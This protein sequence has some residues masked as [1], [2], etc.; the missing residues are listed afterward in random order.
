MKSRKEAD[1]LGPLQDDL[2]VEDVHV[3]E[4]LE[5]VRHARHQGG[6]VLLADQHLQAPHQVLLGLGVVL[7][8]LKHT[9][10]STHISEVSVPCP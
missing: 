8:E 3:V 4:C 6:C 9:S 5:D 10:H 2:L 7:A 1:L